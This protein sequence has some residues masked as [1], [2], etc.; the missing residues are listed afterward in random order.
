MTVKKK[1]KVADLKTNSPS[2]TAS[3]MARSI[4]DP[5]NVN[6]TTSQDLVILREEKKQI[7]F[8]FINGES[9]KC[10]DPESFKRNS[11]GTL[12]K[13]TIK[14][15]KLETF[16]RSKKAFSLNNINYE[17]YSPEKLTLH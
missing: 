16:K 8:S 2:V 4:Q 13:G 15:S 17:T 12:I 7:P 11:K 3:N 9:V 5:T 6:S 1:R 10:A 14:S